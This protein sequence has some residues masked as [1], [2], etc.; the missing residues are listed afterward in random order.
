MPT[1]S[2]S[3]QKSLTSFFGGSS[4]TRK[5]GRS[6][7]TLWDVA[8]SSPTRRTTASRFGTCPLCDASLP[9]HR[10][11]THAAVCNGPKTTTA[12]A[13]VTASMPPKILSSSSSS[14]STEEQSERAQRLP[15]PLWQPRMMV[16]P[17][18]INPAAPIPPSTLQDDSPPGL[19]FFPDF[20]SID[21]EQQLLEFLDNSQQPPW[22]MGRFNGQHSGKRWGVHCNLRDRRV[23]V[24]EHPLPELL[25]SLILPRLATLPCWKEL[26]Q[27]R[28]RRRHR[29]P[30]SN[31]TTHGFIPNEANAIDYRRKRG[32]WL[33]A[34]VDDRKLSTEPIANLSLAGDCIMTFRTTRPSPTTTITTTTT[35]TTTT[36][37]EEYKVPLSRRGLQILTGPAR[38]NYTHAI[39][40]SDLLSDRRVSITMRESPRTAGP[41]TK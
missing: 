29:H 7:V 25:Q 39:A 6:A 17:L 36:T 33:Q 12:T 4:S 37:K 16:E 32:D 40:N 13:T 31:P 22:K 38:Y 41:T 3:Q 30:L 18:S 9:W 26:A 35:T 20:V 1:G 24:P 21:E 34:H 15:H 14:S 2:S 23:D 10:L 5:R 27:Q 19:Y 8:V 28:R 11:E